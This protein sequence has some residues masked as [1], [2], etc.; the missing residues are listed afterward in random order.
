[1]ALGWSAVLGKAEGPSSGDDDPLLASSQVHS[2]HTVLINGF[3][4]HASRA[5]RP[6]ALVSPGVIALLHELLVSGGVRIPHT[7]RQAVSDDA[8]QELTEASAEA[9]TLLCAHRREISTLLEGPRLAEP[10][11]VAA[12]RRHL[13]RGFRPSTPQ[14]ISGVAP[15][16]MSPTS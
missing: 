15:M 6:L 9:G 8:E 10:G 7:C 1:M 12:S 14:I 11:M 4:G 5:I 13:D 2:Q 16:P 3:S